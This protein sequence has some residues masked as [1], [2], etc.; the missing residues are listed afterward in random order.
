MQCSASDIETISRLVEAQ[1]TLVLSTTGPDGEPC[2]APLFYSPGPELKLYWFSSPSSL[3]SANLARDPRAAVA[4]FVPTHMW[5]EIQ[6]VQMRGLA[7]PA[8]DANV[9]QLYRERFHL[10]DMLVTEMN[11][12]TLYVFTPVWIRYLDNTR[13]FGF[14]LEIPQ[15]C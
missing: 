7:R 8:A 12:S 4:I 1:S 15:K 3:H 10:P 14:R 13:R 6:G 9:S 2:A 11:K 5:N